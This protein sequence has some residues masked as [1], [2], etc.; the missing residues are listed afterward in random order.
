MGWCVLVCRGGPSP[1][2]FVSKGVAY[3]PSSRRGGAQRLEPEQVAC[4]TGPALE[5]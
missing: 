5:F 2:G 4:G 3:F 1:R